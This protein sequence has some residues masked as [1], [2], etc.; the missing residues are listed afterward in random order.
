MGR[1]LLHGYT[2]FVQNEI[3]LPENE[4]YSVVSCDTDEIIIVKSRGE[5]PSVPFDEGETDSIFAAL[6]KEIYPYMLEK[7]KLNLD[8]G[9]HYQLKMECETP[10]Y[11][12]NKNKKCYLKYEA[13]TG[14][15]KMKGTGSKTTRSKL[16][17]NKIK[18]FFINC[19]TDP[20]DGINDARDRIATFKNDLRHEIDILKQNQGNL[21]DYCLL[22]KF[23]KS[24]NSSGKLTKSGHL[25]QEHGFKTM[26]R[27]VPYNTGSDQIDY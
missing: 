23:T 15:L 17:D 1:T 5:N 11:I 3:K 24:A 10:Q 22:H 7:H 18:A 8:Q 16:M 20:V 4:K 21:S 6:H 25:E 9:D 19:F 2:D 14:K 26:Y 13:E 12:F 27:V